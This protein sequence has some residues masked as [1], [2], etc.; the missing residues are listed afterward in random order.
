VQ[1][2]NSEVCSSRTS[3]VASHLS[4]P[5]VVGRGGIKDENSVF[6]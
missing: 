4:S 2:K 5:D 1:R 6:C 3:F